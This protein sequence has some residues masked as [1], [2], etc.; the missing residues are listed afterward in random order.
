MPILR[1]HIRTS[2]Q[3]LFDGFDVSFAGSFPNIFRRLP[4]PHNQHGCD[5]CD[6][7]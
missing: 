3:V 1:I 5:D 4:T 2:N 6:Q 7:L